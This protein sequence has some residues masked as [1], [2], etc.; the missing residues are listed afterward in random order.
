VSGSSGIG[1]GIELTTSI[2]KQR[3]HKSCVFPDRTDVTM[4]VPFMNA[5]V[6]LLIQT[7]HK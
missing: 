6:Q 1:A 7:C 2:K 5:Y 3:A 4:T